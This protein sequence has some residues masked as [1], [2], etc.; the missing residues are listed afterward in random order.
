MKK[1]VL[2]FLAVMLILPFAV[3]AGGAQEEAPAVEVGSMSEDGRYVP[4]EKV[5]LSF[6][7]SYS[8]PRAL[9]FEALVE[10]FMEA[11]PK[12]K[13][14]LTYGG[15]LHTM[16][17]KLL[18]SVAGKEAPDI[19]EI[20]SYWTPIFAD[21]GALVD[22][23]PYIEETGF[24]Q[25]DLMDA[26][27]AST[28]YMGKSWSIPFNLSNIVLY[29]NKIAFKEAGLDPE[30]PPAT[31]EELADYAEK[32]TIDKNG[33]GVTDQYGIVF[34]TKANYGAIW[35]YLAF[36][37]QQDGQLFN[38]DLTEGRFNTE[39]G[40][41]AAQYWRDMV[42]KQKALNLSGGW[43][44]FK[45]GNAAMELSSTS[46]LGNYREVMGNANV[47]LA[48]LPKGKKMAT[49]SGGGNLAIFK[50]CK[51]PR[52]AWEFLSWMSSPE[53]NKRWCLST[54]ALPTRK[55]VLDSPEY[56]D[57][58]RTDPKGQIMI[59]GLDFTNIRPNIPE[60]GDASRIIAQAVE[61]AVYD[62]LD[63]APLLDEAKIEVDKLFKD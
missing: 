9:L 32:L 30:V 27:L 11:N 20:D 23:I 48:P 46:V 16:R 60:Y 5:K 2:F 53:V 15:N 37:W 39:A 17:D 14:E 50:D 40:V 21:A 38:A 49:V 1:M 44:E 18:T 4:A 42:W 22:M 51:D 33:D 43:S 45:V 12:I 6:W 10:E 36:F 52:A 24:D 56:Q 62:N 25:S 3:F 35:Y 7:H 54:G 59:D 63:P 55:S 47:G 61:K 34:P 31:W 26:S 58:L 19:A 41:A 57:F 13:I 28:Q 8:G 29:Y